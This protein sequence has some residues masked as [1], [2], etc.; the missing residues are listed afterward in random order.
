[1]SEKPILFSS[2][3]VRAILEGRKTQT[4]R[5]MK[6]QPPDGTLRVEPWIVNGVRQ[7]RQTGGFN[8][9]MPLFVSY[10]REGTSRE[11]ACPYGD[12]GDPLWVRETFGLTDVP[13]SQINRPCAIWPDSNYEDGYAAAIYRA[14]GEWATPNSPDS[15]RFVWRPSIFMP[16]WASRITLEVTDVR[17]ERVRDIS[18]MDARAEGYPQKT[19]PETARDWYHRLWDEINAKRGFGWDV[20]PWVWAI[21]FKAVSNG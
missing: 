1:M 20:N 7:I 17:V 9:R 5:A 15:G 2:A 10:E 8:S 6:T 12:I 16:R 18:E 14:D 11:Y 19:K 4:R 13:V 21:I 3:M